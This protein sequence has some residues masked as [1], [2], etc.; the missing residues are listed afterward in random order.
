MCASL[1]LLIET[2][3]KYLVKTFIYFNYVRNK[4]QMNKN[5]KP[6]FGPYKQMAY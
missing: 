4:K 2:N 3:A 6:P 5:K 1:T